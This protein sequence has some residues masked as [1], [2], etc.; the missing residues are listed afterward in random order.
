MKLKFLGNGSGFSQ[1]HTGA[2]FV[3]NDD[4]KYYISINVDS[5]RLPFVR[6][7]DKLKIRI[8]NK[9]D[10]TEIIEIIG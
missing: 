2:Y 1:T 9:K 3:S 5:K 8:S 10:V 4:S 7:G 6:V